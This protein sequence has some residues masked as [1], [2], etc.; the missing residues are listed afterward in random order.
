M[1]V[2]VFKSNEFELNELEAKTDQELMALCQT[3]PDFT[4]VYLDEKSFQKAFNDYFISDEDYI[5]FVE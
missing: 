1:K 2:L 3:N 5:F 4:E